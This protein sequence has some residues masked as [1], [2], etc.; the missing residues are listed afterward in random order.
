M[1]AVCLIAAAASWLRGSGAGTG[2][3]DHTASDIP[4]GG[5]ETAPALAGN[6]EMII[7]EDA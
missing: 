1:D 4:I 3:T 5:P 6:P 2:K 7:K